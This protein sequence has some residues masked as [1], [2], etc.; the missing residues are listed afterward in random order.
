VLVVDLFPP[1]SHDPRG[2]HGAISEY[3][4]SGTY[5]PTPELPLSLCS[6][7]AVREE[8]V[9]VRCYIEPTSVGKVLIPMPL[10][11]NPGHYVNIPLEP[12]YLAA[13]EGVP[14]RWKR[15]IEG[16]AEE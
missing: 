14:K 3:F 13:Y 8:A 15:V 5:E 6:Y 1:G 10:F 16:A 7:V 12:T 2:I 11:L 4:G 9:A